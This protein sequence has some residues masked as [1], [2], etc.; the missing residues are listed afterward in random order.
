MIGRALRIDIER[1]ISKPEANSLFATTKDGRLTPEM[2]ARYLASLHFM[3]CLTPVHLVRARDAA[4]ARGLDELADHFDKKV[5][6]EV[7]H[8]AWSESDLRTLRAKRAGASGDVA[9]GAR[10]L[11]A[12][13]ESAIDDHPAYYLAYAAFAEFITVMVGPTWVEMLV[14][15]CG[16]PLEALTVITNHIELDG[17][18]AEEG[19]ELMDDLITDPAMLPAMRKILAECMARYDNYC[20][21]CTA[22][23]PAAESGTTLVVEA[24]SVSAA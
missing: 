22:V 13:I 17:A 1:Y 15:R 11:A 21:E 20:A 6:E 2:M 14:Q 18:H 3:I 24:P 16:I 7:G 12:Y 23:V 5:G 4:R 10:E 8:E 9:P 19:F